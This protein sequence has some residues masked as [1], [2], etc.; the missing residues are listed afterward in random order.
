MI[1][2]KDEKEASGKVQTI[3]VGVC[4]VLGLFDV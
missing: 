1:L 2:A 4:G 3:L